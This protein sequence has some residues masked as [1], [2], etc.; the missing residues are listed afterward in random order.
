MS[1]LRSAWV[2]LVV[3]VG[4]ASFALVASAACSASGSPIPDKYRFTGWM[5]PGESPADWPAHLLVEG[6]GG[7]LRFADRWNLTKKPVAYRVCVSKAGS[8]RA[9]C[10]GAKAGI[11]TRPSVLPVS[12]LCCGEFVARW[13]VAGRL[14]ASW[15]FRFIPESSTP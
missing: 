12:V 2:K 3:T 1:R 14:V 8:P 15:P 11:G 9:A 6:D 10:R 4:I 13:Y 7:T 5:A